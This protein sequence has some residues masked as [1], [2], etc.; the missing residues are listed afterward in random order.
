MVG[1][2]EVSNALSSVRNW[3]RHF[4]RPTPNSL[5]KNDITN[6]QKRISCVYLGTNSFEEVRSVRY[7]LICERLVVF[8]C[9]F[10]KKNR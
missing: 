4:S 3:L 1:L 5:G 2:T 10:K 9:V 6:E 7:S 8:C